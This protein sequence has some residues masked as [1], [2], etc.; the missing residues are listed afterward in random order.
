MPKGTQTKT[1]VSKVMP[2]A[3]KRKVFQ[4]ELLR[5]YAVAGRTL[6]WRQTHDPYAIVVS[7]VM[8]QQ[9]QVSRGLPKFI[10]WMKQ[11]PTL[12]VLAQAPLSEVLAAW[13]GLGYNRRA[14]YLWLLAQT[15]VKEYGGIFPQTKEEI[16]ELPGVGPHTAGAI[17]SFAFGQTEP[18]YDTNALRVV[19]RVFKGFS[20]L[21]SLDQKQWTVLM[22][23]TVP[24]RKNIFAFNQALMDLGAMVCTAKKPSCAACP[25][26]SICSSYPAILSASSQQL[27]LT[28]PVK[29]TLYFGQ[30]RRIWRGKI[31]RVLHAQSPQGLTL[32]QLGK[33]IQTDFT[34]ARLPWL[35]SVVQLLEQEGMLRVQE[36]RIV[37]P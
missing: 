33:Q 29:E 17:M 30:P 21:P 16:L 10:A 2:T 36:N 37:L 27:R 8:L 26:S 11:F 14:K 15:V 23:E 20:V 18:I 12:E 9:T 25:L 34:A 35:K 4:R 24:T 22:Q 31:L 13:Q 3:Q 32:Q 7:E 5:W 6:P 1:S 19:G 28:K